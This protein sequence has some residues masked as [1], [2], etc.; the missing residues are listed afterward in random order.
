MVQLKFIPDEAEADTAFL[1]R[2]LRRLLILY[3]IIFLF[4]NF[5]AVEMNSYLWI[6]FAGMKVVLF[7]KCKSFKANLDKWVTRNVG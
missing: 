4:L 2:Y 5:F 7:I 1:Q 3:S 6:L